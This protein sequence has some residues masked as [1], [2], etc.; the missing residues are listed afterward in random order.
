MDVAAQPAAAD[1][2][3]IEDAALL[4]RVMPELSEA[5]AARLVDGVNRKLKQIYLQPMKPWGGAGTMLEL[6]AE[7]A[8]QLA[9]AI[10]GMICVLLFLP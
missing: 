1:G 10:K 8:R 7:E 5:D 2:A 3:A 4:R 9:E 6:S